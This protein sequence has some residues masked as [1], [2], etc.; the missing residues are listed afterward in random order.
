LQLLPKN[1]R[2]LHLRGCDFASLEP[3]KEFKNLQHLDLSRCRLPSLE[4]L[5]ELTDL[6]HLDISGSEGLPDLEFVQKLTK[7]DTLILRGAL[8]SAASLEPL[9]HLT[10][11]KHLDLGQSEQIPDLAPLRLLA[12][13][14][15]LHLNEIESL[16]S[17][18]PLAALTTLQYL[19]L[20][21]SLRRNSAENS[22][23][24]NLTP[25]QFIEMADFIAEAIS[26]V[27]AA[28][29]NRLAPLA[30]L[31]GLKR[32]DL[33]RSRNLPHVNFLSTLH[34]LEIL[35]L[36][37][38]RNLSN[39]DPLAALPA[40]KRLDVRPSPLD[41]GEPAPQTPMLLAALNAIG[42]EILGRMNP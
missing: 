24:F 35:D 11:L 33:S 6:T 5:K 23:A 30:S 10:A 25:A 7:L 36:G 32:L 18:E 34:K 14:E 40:L 15:E 22:I 8:S 13:L 1:L 3:L 4:P 29:N 42:C 37:E 41:P 28:N 38:S 2:E 31:I 9:A 20:A 26:E 39:L 12:N 19:N 27:T 16:P 17:L 21:E